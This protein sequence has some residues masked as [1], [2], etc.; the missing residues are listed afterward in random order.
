[1]R[2][3]GVVVRPDIQFVEIFEQKWP[4]GGIQL[5]W[6]GL[7]GL[8]YKAVVSLNLSKIPLLV[9]GLLFLLLLHDGREWG[10]LRFHRHLY[11]LVLE[12]II[13]KS[14]YDY[15]KKQQKMS[16]QVLIFFF[17]FLLPPC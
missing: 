14:E 12:I 6:G 4:L 9:F 17:C 13:K 7:G 1:M 3:G 8:H 2:Q 16:A 15:V 5:G 11:V 10:C